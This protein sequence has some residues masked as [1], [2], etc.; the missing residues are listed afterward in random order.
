MEEGEDTELSLPTR[1]ACVKLKFLEI[2]ALRGEEGIQ[3]KYTGR[4]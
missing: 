2:A 3:E 4:K 1:S